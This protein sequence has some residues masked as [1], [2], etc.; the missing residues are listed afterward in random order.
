MGH[1]DLE[2]P[3]AEDGRLRAEPRRGRCRTTPGRPAS[4]WPRPVPKIAVLMLLTLLSAP[5]AVAQRATA[6]D[7]TT[8][9][10]GAASL[11]LRSV[12][13]IRFDATA[14][15]MA[16]TTLARFR[17][18]VDLMVQAD[19][20][21][22]IRQFL[23]STDAAGQAQLSAG[24]TFARALGATI[25][26]MP[27]LMHALYDRDDDVIGHIPEG[28][29]S[30]HVV[31]RTAARLSGASP[32]VKVMQMLRIPSGWRVLWSDELAVLEAAL[33]G[34]PRTRVPGRM[35]SGTDSTHVPVSF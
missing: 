28:S 13:A 32:E 23:L 22:E 34:I 31:Y 24:E 11:F 12:R 30:A 15:V 29:D 16:D 10:E 21:G 4:G 7:A 18:V 27:G 25:D 35:Q 26:D 20:S 3:Q 17:L 1:A 19:T 6:A 14:R 5:A 2:A 8:T 33:R 9:P